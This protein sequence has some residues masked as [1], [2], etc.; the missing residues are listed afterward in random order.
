MFKSV[1]SFEGRIRRKEFAIS[2]V[3]YLVCT[4]V[5]QYLIALNTASSGSQDS[6]LLYL[7]AYLLCIILIVAQSVKRCHDLGKSGWYQLIPFYVLWLLFAEG[8]DGVNEYGSNP[9]GIGNFYFSFEK[10]IDDKSEREN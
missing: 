7:L 3:I 10:E 9:K 6:S 2:F 1:F 8:Q 5:L 4:S